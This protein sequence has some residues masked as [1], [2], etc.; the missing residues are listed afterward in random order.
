MLHKGAAIGLGSEANGTKAFLA[1]WMGNG[2]ASW[3]MAWVLK[4]TAEVFSFNL[5]AMP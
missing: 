5:K 2:W 3:D 4:S 1:A